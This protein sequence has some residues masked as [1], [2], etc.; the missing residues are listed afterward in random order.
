MSNAVLP[1]TAGF[2]LEAEKI[3]IW[4]GVEISR[5]QSMDETAVLCQSYPLYEINL[6]VEVLREAFLGTSL[7]EA[8]ALLGFFNLRSGSYD[9]F[10]YSDPEDYTVTDQTFGVRDGT[11]T[12]FQ[13]VRTW[14]G[15]SE[16]VE[17]VNSLTN[18]KSNGGA[19]TS[20]TNY[21][22][23]STGLVTLTSAGTAGHVLTW[24]GTYYW[25]VR[26][27]AARMA[28]RRMFRDLHE[29]KN[30]PLL[31]SVQNKIAP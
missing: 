11:T 6:S 3:A 9:S 4:D 14:G 31:G 28:F 25:R 23:S 15:Y 16:P 27:N 29:L 8:R 2:K 24:S 1:V 18:L 30:L 10:L 21:S 5:S 22:I 7:N 17:N 12:Q 26:F 19:L 20:P 13:L